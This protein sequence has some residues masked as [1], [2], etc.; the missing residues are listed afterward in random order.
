MKS[1]TIAG[2]TAVMAGLA[3]VGG[4]IAAGASSPHATTTH[5]VGTWYDDIPLGDG[6][7]WVLWSNGYVKPF[8]GAINYGNASGRHLNNF[9]GMVTDPGDD[10]YWLITSTG[11]V[12][13]YGRVCNGNPIQNVNG[14][15]H[16]NVIGG[17]FPKGATDSEGYTLVTGHGRLYHFP[18]DYT[19]PQG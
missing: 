19:G 4:T 17:I 6:G 1:R 2:V 9:V 10:G 14:Y 13:T 11:N 3:I 15:P 8:D 5:I 16:Y 18:C 12:F 7:G